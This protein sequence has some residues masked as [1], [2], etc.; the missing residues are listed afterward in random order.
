MTEAGTF[1]SFLMSYWVSKKCHLSTRM[2]FIKKNSTPEEYN[3]YSNLP[4]VT[5]APMRVGRGITW[6]LFLWFQTILAIKPNQALFL[7]LN[8]L[9]ASKCQSV[10]TP[11][12][13]KN[14]DI[15]EIRLAFSKARR[16]NMNCNWIFRIIWQNVDFG[17]VQLKMCIPKQPTS[18]TKM[19]KLLQNLPA[20]G[21]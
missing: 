7:H 14:E 5:S 13:N 1:Q 2:I 12:N 8:M 4:G 16:K 17:F 11:I 3:F 10:E 21:I 15:S 19:E 18:R 6:L 20:N 9:D